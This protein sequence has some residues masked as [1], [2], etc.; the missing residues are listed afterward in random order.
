M[1]QKTSEQHTYSFRDNVELVTLSVVV[2]NGFVIAV[3]LEHIRVVETS[4]FTEPAIKK[5][6]LSIPVKLENIKSKMR[7]M[8]S[9]TLQGV[10]LRM[11]KEEQ[12]R[13]NV[14]RC[15]RLLKTHQDA[16]KARDDELLRAKMEEKL[17]KEKRQRNNIQRC[18]HLLKAQ[19]NVR[20][21]QRDISTA[22]EDS[23]QDSD[24]LMS[25]SDYEK[26]EAAEKLRCDALCADLGG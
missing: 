17:K 7:Y 11:E 23:P 16:N 10:F 15:L 9:L 1:M 26:M 24:I 19:Q 18:L 6:R 12:Q 5:L 3:Y 14:Q 22:R 2:K 13:R 21:A 25:L 20:T 4:P 8:P